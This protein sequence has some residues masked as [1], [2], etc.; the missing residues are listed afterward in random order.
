MMGMGNETGDAPGANPPEAA[1]AGAS[2]SS[3]SARHGR[4]SKTRT[5]PAARVLDRLT[6]IVIFAL[7]VVTPWAFGSAHALT[8]WLASLA[9]MALGGMLVAKRLV[10]RK[11]GFQPARW[12]DGGPRWFA[13]LLAALTALLVLGCL[14]AAWR[15]QAGWTALVQGLGLAGSFWAARDWFLGKTRGERHMREHSVDEEE[16]EEDETDD[17]E[18]EGSRGA[19]RLPLRV[20][21]LLWVLCLNTAVLALV[22]ILQR[23]DGTT[24]LLW[25]WQPAPNASSYA[26]FG[27]FP[28]HA[29]AARYLNLVWPVC[30]GFWWCLRARA[31]AVRRTTAR[32]GGSPHVLLLPCAVTMAAAAVISASRSGAVTALGCG[33]GALVLL[34][35]SPGGERAKRLASTMVF[36]VLAGI[37]LALGW[38]QLGS[39]MGASFPLETGGFSTPVAFGA[40]LV[41]LVAVARWFLPGGIVAP[42]MLVAFLWLGLGGC[43]IPV[44][45]GLAPQNHSVLFLFTLLACLASCLSRPE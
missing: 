30:L 38:S 35:A 6:A 11:A 5:P 32:A 8:V 28:R 23:L 36:L 7:L 19:R 25:L 20:R 43:L 14:M 12:G 24:Q 44:A 13:Y 22:S 15:G 2:P 37:A 27:P 39:Q 34:A 31:G 21:R 26:Q 18:A 9:G 45:F 16:S 40:G 10:C 41:L 29:D 17:T 3:R 42:K 33:A 4:R 1:D